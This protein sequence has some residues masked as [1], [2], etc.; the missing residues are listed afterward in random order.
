MVPNKKSKFILMEKLKMSEPHLM[1]ICPIAVRTIH[2]NHNVNITVALKGS[3]VSRI[4]PLSVCK[5]CNINQI[6]RPT[7]CRQ[8]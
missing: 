6:D 1:A 8:G 4:H 5:K 3:G 7:C 2:F